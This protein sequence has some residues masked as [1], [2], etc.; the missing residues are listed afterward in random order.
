MTKLD[1][2]QRRP[3]TDADLMAFVDGVL[4][5]DRRVAVLDHIAAD[6]E[7][8]ERV[9]AYLH[10]NANL[11]FLGQ[12]LDLS[13]ER[14]FCPRLQA[15]LVQA[16]RQTPGR[17]RSRL[18]FAADWLPHW[19]P[20]WAMAAGVALC[21]GLAGLT[22]HALRQDGGATG[23]AV[24]IAAVAAPTAPPAGGIV[25]AAAM[26]VPAALPVAPG[27]PLVLFDNASLGA[28][29]DGDASITW[30][31]QRLDNRS[32]VRPDLA[33]LGLAFKGGHI[34]DSTKVPAI[35]LTYE[36]GQKRSL[37]LYVGMLSDGGS[38]HLLR[39]VPED[40]VS[41]TWRQGPLVFAIVAPQDSLGLLDAMHQVRAALG[42]G[43]AE[44]PPALAAPAA[45]VQT[46]LLP[47][48]RGGTFIVPVPRPERQVVAETL[49]VD[50]AHPLPAAPEAI[51]VGTAQGGTEP[52]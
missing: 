44:P 23:T 47:T 33:P 18:G 25:E 52:L 13:D 36:D 20:N 43:A 27:L 38:D 9:E 12:A 26:T 37:T 19:E 28:E 30:L 41:M 3:V 2:P 39:L 15:D 35:S 40:Q 5:E 31:R 17:S 11:R 51:E 16:L 8:A 46:F 14:V 29:D 49:V 1:M 45:P 32:F 4:D 34:F 10:Q 42:G 24:S 50:P 22:A 21:I 7:A 6:A 48:E